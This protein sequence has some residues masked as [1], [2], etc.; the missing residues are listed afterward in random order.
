M[1]IV[2]KSPKM[3]HLNFSILTFSPI[4]VQWTCLVTLFHCKLQLFKIAKMIDFGIF[5]VHSNVEWDL[6]C[7]FQPLWIFDN[8]WRF[9]KVCYPKYIFFENYS[10]CRIW[11][12]TILA[13]FTNFCTNKNNMSGNTGFQKLA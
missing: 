8:K 12:F 13:F 2:W 7:D 1:H 3:S 10:K 6:F 11:T 4:F 9:E 5:D